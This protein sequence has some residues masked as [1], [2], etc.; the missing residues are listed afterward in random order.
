[1]FKFFRKKQPAAV[2]VPVKELHPVAPGDLSFR[3]EF[4]PEQAKQYAV[5]LAQL[6]ANPSNI[7]DNLGEG[8]VFKV[9]YT[10]SGGDPKRVLSGIESLR[11]C[12][13]LLDDWDVEH[14]L[15]VPELKYMIQL[16]SRLLEQLHA[17]EEFVS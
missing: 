7:A 16:Y 6:N 2:E 9:K 12:R 10:V 13:I 8:D 1:M 5:L 14:Q 3:F 11:L 15:S 4:P 17:I